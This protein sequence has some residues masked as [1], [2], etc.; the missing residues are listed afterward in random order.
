MTIIQKEIWIE[1]DKLTTDIDKHILT[2]LHKLENTCNKKHGY[3]LN[4]I[5]INSYDTNYISP[6]NSNI[7]FM[8]NFT[9][10]TLKPN[11]DDIFEGTVE[12]IFQ[13]G[14]I[15]IVKKKMK[16]L[17]PKDK[18]NNYVYNPNGLCFK[19]DDEIITKGHKI[20]VL[21]INLR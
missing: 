4:I 13:G 2:Q 1:P 8:V 9:A 6:A 5:K 12:I 18:M 15:L 16:T 14:I 21:I 7:V 17:I 3:I 19:R 11:T 20:K 10:D